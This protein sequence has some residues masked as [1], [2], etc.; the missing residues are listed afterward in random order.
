MIQLVP[1]LLFAGFIA[2]GW[3]CAGRTRTPRSGAPGTRGVSLF[4]AY[5][6]A[7]T[8]AAGVG[9]KNLWPFSNWPLIAPVVPRDVRELHILAVDADGVAHVVD[10]RAWEPM[11]FRE[12]NAWVARYLVRMDTAVQDSAAAILLAMAEAARARARAGG[13]IGLRDRFLGPL[14]A[15]YFVLHPAWWD[16]PAEVP[17]N[18]FV[19]LR[20][21]WDTWD[22]VAV[23]AGAPR[24][25]RRVVYEHPRR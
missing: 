16:D 22:V 20:L 15:P 5:T 9:Q 1:A 19:G 13:G 7:A 14:A 11:A 4:L 12:L 6:M 2:V 23:A 21:A 10:H 24:G 3:V 18:P 8:F 25:P 17:A